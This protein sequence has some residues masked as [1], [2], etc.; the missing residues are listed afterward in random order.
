VGIVCAGVG[1]VKKERGFKFKNPKL[2]R[3]KGKI[4]AKNSMFQSVNYILKNIFSWLN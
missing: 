2:I 3:A 1:V 4:K